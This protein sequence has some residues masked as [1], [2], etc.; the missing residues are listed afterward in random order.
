MTW[1]AVHQF[2][3]TLVSG[4]AIGSHALWIQQHLRARGCR[5]E[6]FVG[7]DNP[8]TLAETRQL[9]LV[10]R[11]VRSER[12]TLLLY[13]VA[14]ASYCAD[15]LLE[16]QE[17]L[18]LVF[19]N[20]TPP[21]LLI[22]WDPDTAFELLRAQEQLLDL[23]DQAQFAICD[24]EFNARSLASFGN[25]ETAVVPLPLPQKP[26]LEQSKS[27]H[28]IILFVGR[29]A[30]N[31]AIHD[32]IATVALLHQ[33]VPGAELRIVGGPTSDLYDASLVGL[34]NALGL[35]D[36]VTFTGWVSDDQLEREYQQASVFCT[37]SDHEGF[38]VPILEAMTHGLPVVAFEST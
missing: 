7:I 17:P 2:V 30:P 36:I 22:H 25:L 3:P 34:V 35:N 28:P 1:D 29:V 31:K 23:V 10:D 38:G 19:H 14:Q 4:D 11:Y 5:S 24:S 6:I 21:E 13:H 8:S 9:E 33:N 15:F 26:R 32:L 12:R 20:F 16:R 37:L 27:E 18:A